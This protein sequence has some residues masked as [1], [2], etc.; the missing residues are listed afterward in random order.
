MKSKFLAALVGLV[1][2]TFS[3]VSGNKVNG[4][5]HIGT[6]KGPCLILA[7]HG[8][9]LDFAFGGAALAPKRYVGV[10]AKELFYRP[11]LGKFLKKAGF[12]S[13]QQFAVDARCIRSIKSCLDSGVSVFIC[14]E[15][16]R[17]ADGRQSYL[18][19]AIAKLVKWANVP[20]V[21]AN[22]RGSYLS[23]PR[24]GGFFRRGK[25]QTD[26]RILYARDSIAS[27]DC[28]QIYSDLK[29]AL[30][31]ND[32]EYQE[33]CGIKFRTG[34]PA[35]G[36]HRLLYKCPACHA[37][38]KT[39]GKKDKLY[40]SECGATVKVD[41]LGRL[42][43]ISGD[44]PFDR[45]D[46]WADYEIETLKQQCAY[47]DFSMSERVSL[48]IRNDVLKAEVLGELTLDRTGLTFVPDCAENGS[49]SKLDGE[50]IADCFCER[51]NI[52]VSKP[53]ADSIIPAAATEGTAPLQDGGKKVLDLTKT[54]FYPLKAL[55]TVAFRNDAII[56][57]KDGYMHYY[58]FKEDNK[59]YKWNYA[60]E[61]LHRAAFKND[62]EY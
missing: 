26:V 48:L 50:R 34:N 35:K 12:I 15:G 2:R 4:K 62:K 31:F 37:E 21:S 45:V 28:N 61:V 42:I 43:P 44:I 57:G 53:D 58:R 17:T 3:L 5:K 8:S 29:K 38:F 60:V 20:V 11:V 32:Y 1:F 41:L 18:P 59:T 46:K 13:K 52:R 49:P 6:I 39:L 47:S 14:P 22:I 51:S 9:T 55:P 27:A 7:T 36:L 24:W 25:I 19:P 33:S 16:K 30:T 54:V 23:L 40:C 10:V 56:L